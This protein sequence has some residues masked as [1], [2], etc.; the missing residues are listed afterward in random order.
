MSLVNRDEYIKYRFQ[1]ALE[2]YEEALI[3]AD[4]KRWNAV[5]NRLYYS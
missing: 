3:M 4:N 5:I 2:S 1:R